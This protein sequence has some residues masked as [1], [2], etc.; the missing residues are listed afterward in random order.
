VQKNT[1]Y[2]G[3]NPRPPPPPIVYN[4]SPIRFGPSRVS[5]KDSE[6]LQR[7]HTYT[8]HFVT[9]VTVLIVAH[10]GPKHAGVKQKATGYCHRDTV[11]FLALILR[12]VLLS[13]E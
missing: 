6:Q 1:L 5:I 4:L 10:E 2:L 13:Y 12:L 9:A 3:I 11:D 8:V 7:L